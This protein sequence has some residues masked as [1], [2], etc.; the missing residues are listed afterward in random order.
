MGKTDVVMKVRPVLLLENEDR[1]QEQEAS[2]YR[3]FS[4]SLA[5]GSNVVV[6][7]MC[8]LIKLYAY[9]VLI[10]SICM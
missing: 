8:I 6:F 10:F 9:D 4:I 5:A 3:S 2:E 1:L 7:T